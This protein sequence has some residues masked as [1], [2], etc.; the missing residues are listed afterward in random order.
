[1]ESF[2]YTPESGTA[3]ITSCQVDNTSAL[4]PNNSTCVV[5]VLYVLSKC[6]YDT[7]CKKKKQDGA[8]TDNVGFDH[9]PSTSSNNEE[10]TITT[11]CPVLN[12]SAPAARTL[13]SAYPL[14]RVAP[15][16]KRPVSTSDMT[17]TNV[18]SSPAGTKFN[19]GVNKMCEG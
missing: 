9:L 2:L 10:C 8:N 17:V 5:K 18:I 19:A 16:P 3:S 14:T 7:S 15:A 12:S 1:M 13:M 11:F 4:K 6:N